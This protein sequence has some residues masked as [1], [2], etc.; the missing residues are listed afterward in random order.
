MKWQSINKMAG[1]NFK[2]ERTKAGISLTEID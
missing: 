2:A 1:T